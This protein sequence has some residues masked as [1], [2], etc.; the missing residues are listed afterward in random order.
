MT[1]AVHLG[2]FFALRPLREC[3]LC[4]KKN[5]VLLMAASLVTEGGLTDEGGR[6]EGFFSECLVALLPSCRRDGQQVSRANGVGIV[7]MTAVKLYP[8]C[9]ILRALGKKGHH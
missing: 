3:Q 6:D 8:Y 9:I 4:G 1:P 7:N 5:S 2:G